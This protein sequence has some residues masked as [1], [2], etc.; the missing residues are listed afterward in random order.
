MTVRAISELYYNDNWNQYDLISDT[1]ECTT[2]KQNCSADT[3]CKNTKVSYNCACKPG[4]SGD[5]R[6]CKGRFCFFVALNSEY[7]S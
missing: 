6:D 1:Y 7:V 4:Y 5:G 3:V 2:E